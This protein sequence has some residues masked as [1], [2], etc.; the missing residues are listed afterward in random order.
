MDSA[1]NKTSYLVATQ[2]PEFVRRDH[3]KFIEFLESYYKWMEQDGE[4]MY[5]AKRLS[6]FYDIDTLNQDIIDEIHEEEADRYHIILQKFYDNFLNGFP[7]KS[8]S[9]RT[10]ILKHAKDFYR[11]T[12]TE[13]SFKF[14]MRALYDKESSF[15]YPQ[16]NILRAS[17]GK[18]FV[19]KS[20]NI[21][22]ITVNGQANT[23]ALYR[24]ANTTVRGGTSNST[25]VVESVNPYYSAGV[26]ITE[27]I[28]SSVEK[29]FING[30]PLTAT[31]EDE[32]V[33][34]EL[35]A[36]IFS[37]IVVRAT[38]TEPG[39]A[40][41]QGSVVPVIAANGQGATIVISKVAQ[42]RLQ[43]QIKEVSITFSGA[44]YQA[45]TPL[46]FTGGGGGSGAEANITVV[47][48]SETYHP[49]SYSIIGSTIDLEADTPLDSLVYA[50][51]NSSNINTT[52]ANAMSYWTY[53]NCGPIIATAMI[54]AGVN[55]VELPT[56]SVLSNTTIRSLGILGRMD[57]I[58]GGVGYQSGDVIEFINPYGTYGIGA[59]AQVSLV[60]SNGSITQVS[61]FA[62][63]GH[64]PG[65]SGY[66]QNILPIANVISQNVNAYGANIVVSACL[67]DGSQL[68]AKSNVIGSI[69]EL[70]IISGGFGYDQPPILDLSTQGDGTALAYANI[71]TGIYTYPGR[72]LNQDG[73]ISSYSFL[74]DRDYYQK[75]SY[76]IKVE[77]SM[78]KYRTALN[79]LIHPA[80]MKMFGEYQFSD[81]NETRVNTV[82]VINTQITVA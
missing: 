72:Y 17:D 75:F 25:C 8:L 47:D 65:G 3:P 10:I 30:E 18:W 57:I 61:W 46:L 33:F 76:V 14:G 37:G 77:E 68:A 6:D 7:N 63:P 64:L 35:S 20:I 60:D 38:I 42:A 49:E 19:Q 13:K 66:D 29:D 1:N 11:S 69:A 55:Y 45:N 22:D 67:A 21:R 44:G 31:I 28:I 15:Y 34:K 73:Q 23:D 26:L 43:G 70:K 32:G 36:N 51:L 80:G 74:E 41:V 2:L 12:G 59:N 56:V 58:S 40:Y 27:L 39:S 54:E 48:V 79:D 9:D 81:N 82:N 53:A 5:V 71:V 16:D 52:I 24:F 4:S 50:N 62:I 78:D